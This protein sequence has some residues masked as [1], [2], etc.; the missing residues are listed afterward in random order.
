[1]KSILRSLQASSYKEAA[2]LFNDIAK[3]SWKIIKAPVAP[4][5]KL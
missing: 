4:I 1:M 5:V 2:A 3:K